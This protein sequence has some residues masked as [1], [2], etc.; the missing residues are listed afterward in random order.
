LK[1]EIAHTHMIVLLRRYLL[2]ELLRPQCANCRQYANL[3][4]QRQG[5]YYPPALKWPEV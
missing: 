2:R 5:I 1:K 3:F 4:C